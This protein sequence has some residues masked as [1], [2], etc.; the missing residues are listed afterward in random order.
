MHQ[1]L[2]D[3]IT[4]EIVE[5]TNGIQFGPSACRVVAVIGLNELLECV[6][7]PGNNIELGASPVRKIA[8]LPSAIGKLSPP[9]GVQIGDLHD[10]NPASRII[11]RRLKEA[12]VIVSGASKHKNGL[13]PREPGDLQ[14]KEELGNCITGEI[15]LR[16]ANPDVVWFRVC[17]KDYVGEVRRRGSFCGSSGVQVAEHLGYK[18]R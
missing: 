13:L 17:V 16:E 5:L 8:V 3:P 12:L 14:V 4:F 9:V 18:T 15:Y 6:P 10:P 1:Q 11:G 7:I 2:L